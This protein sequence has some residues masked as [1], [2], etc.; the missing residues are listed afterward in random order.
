MADESLTATMLSGVVIARARGL[1]D[2]ADIAAAYAVRAQNN[3]AGESWAAAKG[4][5]REIREA[6]SRTL[7]SLNAAPSPT[8][9]KDE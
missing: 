6:H 2:A 8:E 7:A 3:G 5:E 4:I 1:E 9:T